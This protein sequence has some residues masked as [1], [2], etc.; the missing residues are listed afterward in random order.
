MRTLMLLFFGV[1]SSW[2]MDYELMLE[3]P[4]IFAP[5]TDGPPGSIN[6]RQAVNLDNFVIEHESDILH[7]SGNATLIWDVRPT[8]RIAARV[9]LLHFN[10]GTWEPTIFS[11]SN[12]DFCP[13]MYD[14][15]QYWYK[16]WTQY[17]SNQHEVA[18]KCLREPGTVLE[19]E[20]FDLR[21]KIEN[22]HGPTLR[23]R[24]KMVI[25]L[26]AFDEKNIPRPNSICVEIRGE[27]LKLK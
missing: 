8:D 15:N 24:H 11:I 3:D 17:V 26:Q 6:A 2:A 18:K 13:I 7:L 22:V 4:D 5:C 12:Q 1:T 20:P 19:H 21:L 25:K 14:K 27:L 16:Y 10:R 23:G 9:D